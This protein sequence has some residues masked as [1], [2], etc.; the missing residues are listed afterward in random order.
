MAAARKTNDPRTI[1]RTIAAECVGVRVR[2]LNRAMTRIYDRLLRP[3][4]IKFSQMNILTAVTLSGP[5]QPIEVTRILSI[6]KSTLSRNVAIMEANGWIE[7]LAGD[8][9]NTR[10]LRVTRKG[11][12]LLER[13]APAW[14]AAQ[15][16]VTSLL[17][18]RT[19]TALRSAVDR[20]RKTESTK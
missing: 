14:S 4:G 11:G 2:M 7:S 19:A 5:V 17:G 3:H 9:G 16:Q 20:L 18:E 8:V 15:E 12:R 6:E 10:L 13:A 1:A